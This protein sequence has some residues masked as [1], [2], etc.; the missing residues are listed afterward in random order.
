MH[1]GD[2]A[3]LKKKKYVLTAPTYGVRSEEG[4]TGSMASFFFCSDLR[5][6]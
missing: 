4:I 5:K 3:Y 2:G 6:H 1:A